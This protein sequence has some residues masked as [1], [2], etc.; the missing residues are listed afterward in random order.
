M[1]EKRIIH[2]IVTNK[3][4]LPK[5]STSWMMAIYWSWVIYLIFWGR[6]LIYYFLLFCIGWYLGKTHLK[7]KLV[8]EDIQDFKEILREEN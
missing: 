2:W 8:E 7:I 3:Y 4:R 6:H 5:P 1:I